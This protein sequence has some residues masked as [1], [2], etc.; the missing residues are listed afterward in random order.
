VK[1]KLSLIF[2][3]VAHPYIN[4]YLRGCFFTW[5]KRGFLKFDIVVLKKKTDFPLV[6]RTE[7]F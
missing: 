1:L 5:T 6:L 4:V 7:S 3:I 2:N